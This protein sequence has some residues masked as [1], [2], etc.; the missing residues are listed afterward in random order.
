MKLRRRAFLRLA[1]GAAAMP[2]I[3]RIAWPQ[4][5]P[6]R[7][8]TM[9]VPFAAG[10]PLDAVGRLLTPR[11]SEVLGQQ[12]I[13]ENVSGAGVHRLRQSKPRQDTI[14]LG[15]RRVGDPH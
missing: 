5:Y 9:I 15:W 8:L 7:P 1:V 10:G 13:I 6:T 11:L 4:N 14:W 3:S 2:T 12:V